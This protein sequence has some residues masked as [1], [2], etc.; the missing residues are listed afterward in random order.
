[1]Q[2]GLKPLIVNLFQKMYVEIK[3]ATKDEVITDSWN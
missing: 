3:K 1:L 2:I